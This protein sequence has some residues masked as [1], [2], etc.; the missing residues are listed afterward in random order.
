MSVTFSGQLSGQPSRRVR[1]AVKDGIAVAAFSATA[2]C[3]LAVAL[4][5]LARLAQ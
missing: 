5:M 2:S 3:V 4:T 1:H